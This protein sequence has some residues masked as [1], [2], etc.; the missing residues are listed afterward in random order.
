[1]SITSLRRVR[2]H[3][4]F[5]IAVLAAMAVVTSIGPRLT[6]SSPLTPGNIV[7]YRV[8]AGATSLVNTGNEVFLDEYTTGGVLVQSIPLPTT[9]TATNHRLIASGTATSE[10]LM[11]RSADGLYLVLSGYD[12]AIPTTGLAGT[13]S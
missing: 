12:A 6:A 3:S 2:P 11:T 13:A 9:V 8:G 10:G 4:V 1:M 7:I 5:V